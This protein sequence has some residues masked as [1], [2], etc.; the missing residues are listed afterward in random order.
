VRLAGL[1]V[2]AAGSLP[3]VVQA[4]AVHDVTVAFTGAQGIFKP[5]FDSLLVFEVFVEF[6]DH[7][8]AECLLLVYFVVSILFLICF[9]GENIL[10]LEF[11]GYNTNFVAQ[12]LLVC[13]LVGPVRDQP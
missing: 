10:L 8:V 12:D 6:A 2:T 7:I 4:T 3:E 1:V 11:D 5:V 13:K 9:L